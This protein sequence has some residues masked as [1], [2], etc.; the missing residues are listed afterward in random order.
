MKTV[1][2][3]LIGVINDG[4]D[5]KT[6]NI[7]DKLAALALL[8]KQTILTGNDIGYQVTFNIRPIEPMDIT[9]IAKKTHPK[10]RKSKGKWS[11]R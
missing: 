7:I 1:T 11:V 2:S 3:G 8:E 5:Q 4:I 6:V 10:M 9:L